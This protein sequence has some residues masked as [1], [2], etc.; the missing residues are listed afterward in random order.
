MGQRALNFLHYHHC[1]R[2]FSSYFFGIIS[3]AHLMTIISALIEIY[4]H[5]I[6]SSGF[7]FIWGVKEFKLSHEFYT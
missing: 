3:T 5:P 6:P 2:L 4:V 7:F 1:H